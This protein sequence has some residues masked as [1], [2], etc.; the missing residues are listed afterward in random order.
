HGSWASRLPRKEHARCQ[1][2]AER[3]PL[4]LRQSRLGGRKNP[5]EARNFRHLVGSECRIA[6]NSLRFLQISRP[7][8]R[9]TAML[10]PEVMVAATCID[11]TLE[12][13][14]PLAVDA[15]V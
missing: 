8:N 6:D 12:K 15:L 11:T 4:R 9:G 14:S 10:L 3:I 2:R 13:R 7:A 5:Q 1:R